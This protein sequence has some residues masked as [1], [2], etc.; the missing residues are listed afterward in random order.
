MTRPVLKLHISVKFITANIVNRATGDLVATAST[1]E[2]CIKNSFECGRSSNPK[3][4][5]AVGEVLA[6]RFK[7]AS[8]SGGG[9]VAAREIYADVNGEI[10]KKG[11]EKSK[12]I[13]CVVNSLRNDGLKIVLDDESA[14]GPSV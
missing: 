13:W 1:V 9:D 7:I 10:E 8:F 3:A 11:C 4:A 6:K 14:S 12:M 5:A 2:H